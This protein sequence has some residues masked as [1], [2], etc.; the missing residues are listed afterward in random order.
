MRLTCA[1]L[2]QSNSTVQIRPPPWLNLQRKPELD[3]LPLE[4]DFLYGYDSLMK[5]SEVFLFIGITSLPLLLGN[6]CHLPIRRGFL[7]IQSVHPF[8]PPCQSDIFDLKQESSIFR[9]FIQ[10]CTE[11][12]KFVGTCVVARRSDGEGKRAR[13]RNKEARDFT[14]PFIQKSTLLSMWFLHD[15]TG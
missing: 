11:R 12:C 5:F 13:W 6:F 15:G 4:L 14:H 1:I 7:S 8:R 10:P 3:L 2:K 9:S